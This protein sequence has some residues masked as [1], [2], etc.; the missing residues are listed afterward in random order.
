M[1]KEELT[2]GLLRA[3][4]RTLSVKGYPIPLEIP[5]AEHLFEVRPNPSLRDSKSPL[6]FLVP[7]S[8]EAASLPPWDIQKS[9]FAAMESDT[10]QAVKA[11]AGRLFF[12][13]SLCHLT[14]FGTAR[15]KN[16]MLE[17]M[18]KS[19]MGGYPLALR[20]LTRLHTACGRQSPTGSLPDNSNVSEVI[21][22]DNLLAGQHGYYSRRLQL[23]NSAAQNS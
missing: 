6:T 9:I 18:I 22:I 23:Y 20:V 14:G 1:F 7:Q 17:S 19:A 16:K 10:E 3:T 4:T 13:L 2:F 5:R 15:D 11:A 21:E 8:L 12:D